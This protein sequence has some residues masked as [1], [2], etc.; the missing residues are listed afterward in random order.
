MYYQHYYADQFPDGP[1]EMH[2]MH[3]RHCLH[4]VLQSL[5][6]NANVDIVPHR[7]VANDDVPFAQFSIQRKCRNFNNL[8]QWNQENAVKNVR[9]V[10][11]HTKDGMPKDA[12]VWPAFGEQ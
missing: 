8:R 2:W 5:T 1:D 11:P 6:C 7:W 12:F 9:D 10:W 4:M 3:Q